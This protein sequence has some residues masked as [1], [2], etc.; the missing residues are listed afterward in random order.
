VL[1]AYVRFETGMRI[2]GMI[3]QLTKLLQGY[4]IKN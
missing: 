4:I 1:D 2:G 3:Q